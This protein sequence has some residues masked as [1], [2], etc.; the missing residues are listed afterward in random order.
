[1]LLQVQKHTER[2]Q[3]E[4]EEAA[5]GKLRLALPDISPAVLALALQEGSW[6][7]DKAEQLI[8]LFL[9]AKGRQ[10]AELQKVLYLEGA[11]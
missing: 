8:Q 2:L 9:S 10:L 11:L 4:K 6:E 5:M 3:K 7:T 1:M